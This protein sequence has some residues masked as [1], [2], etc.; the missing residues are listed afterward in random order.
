MHPK[1]GDVQYCE[2]MLAEGLASL[3]NSH[4]IEHMEVK[5]GWSWTVSDRDLTAKAKEVYRRMP[6]FMRRLDVA[7]AG[8][9]D[10]QK[11]SRVKGI[12]LYVEPWSYAEKWRTWWV[13]DFRPLIDDLVAQPLNEWL[14]TLSSSGKFLAVWLN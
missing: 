10:E 12:K 13:G 7:L 9:L 1:S 5:L 14:P 8:F 11:Y 3:R 4:S 6:T 2:A